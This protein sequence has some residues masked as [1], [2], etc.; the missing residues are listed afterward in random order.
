MTPEQRKVLEFQ[1]KSGRKC[2]KTPTFADDEK[3]H[4]LRIDL[5]KEEFGEFQ[6][7][8]KEKDLIEIADAIGDL[9][10]VVYGAANAFG[11]DMEPIFN[12]IH[13]S[14]MTKDFHSEAE[15][16]IHCKVTKGKNYSPPQIDSIILSQIG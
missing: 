10:Y 13:R 7:A 16:K 15:D 2:P 9:L 8:I 3:M 12:E 6:E 11:I 4:K 5:I 14:N 1:D